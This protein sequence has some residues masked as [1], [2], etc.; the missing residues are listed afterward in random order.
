MIDCF[1]KQGDAVEAL[2]VKDEMIA[3]GI[4]L[5]FVAYAT[6]I[7]GVCRS[8]NMDGGEIC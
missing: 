4:N 6:L 1:M 2:R 8:G 7:G 3:C 5:K